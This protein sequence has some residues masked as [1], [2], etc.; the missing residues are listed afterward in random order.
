MDL[1]VKRM[2]QNT[3]KEMCCR[4]ESWL[5]SVDHSGHGITLIQTRHISGSI[6]RGRTLGTDVIAKVLAAATTAKCYYQWPVAEL[7]TPANEETSPW[8]HESRLRRGE[9]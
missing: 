4:V 1:R 5:C 2:P 3:D 7:V 9:H 6:R 8:I